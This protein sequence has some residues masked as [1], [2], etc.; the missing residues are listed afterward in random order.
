MNCKKKKEEFEE[1]KRL[2]GTRDERVME[3]ILQNPTQ[4]YVNL[5]VMHKILYKKWI[6]NFASEDIQSIWK[7]TWMIILMVYGKKKNDEEK[8]EDVNM[9]YEFIYLF[10]DKIVKI[11]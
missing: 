2:L 4:D 10:F 8:N 1:I 6:R 7:C 5:I 3:F 11:K 9:V